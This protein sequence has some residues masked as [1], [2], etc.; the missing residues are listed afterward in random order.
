[1]NKSFVWGLLCL[2]LTFAPYSYAQSTAPSCD[3]KVAIAKTYIKYV[4]FLSPEL[5]E[6]ILENIKPCLDAGN[7]EASYITA[8]LSLNDTS[9]EQDEL[10]SFAIVKHAAE[11]GNVQA[12]TNLALMYK[13]G[14][15][16]EVNLERSLHWFN[17]ASG[18]GDS[19]ATYAKGYFQMKGLATSNQNYQ[20]ALQNLTST[21]YPM[22]KHWEATCHY[23]GYGVPVDT[24]KA[25]QLLE[26]NK[27][28]NSDILLKFLNSQSTTTPPDLSSQQEASIHTYGDFEDISPDHIKQAYIGKIAEYDWSINQLKRADPLNFNF[29]Y[30]HSTNTATYGL[31]V[32]G[33]KKINDKAEYNNNILH[34][35]NAVF[36]MKNLYKDHPDRDSITYHITAIKFDLVT[37]GDPGSSKEYLVGKLDGTII[38]WQEPIP[39][40][41][42]VL[43]P[44]SFGGLSRSTVI[45]EPITS[46][47]FPNPFQN[48]F[49]IEYSLNDPSSVHIEVYNSTG[50]RVLTSGT[51][52]TVSKGNHKQTFQGSHL[53]RGIYLVKLTVNGQQKKISKIIKI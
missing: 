11:K 1:M 16:T 34:P 31:L 28:S 51:K 36:R 21:N 25:M 4:E 24:S 27:I 14:I 35:K 49:V 29:K 53:R 3:Q 43:T 39:P 12:M 37:Q 15:G 48:E 32:S 2:A 52:A 44:L 47:A 8:V 6:D 18:K 38:E 40:M 17:E 41:F 22:A 30:D 23:F 9:T 45:A 19:F 50:I 46:K 13:N 33:N 5:K 26:D 7:Q 42:V 10:I 20:E